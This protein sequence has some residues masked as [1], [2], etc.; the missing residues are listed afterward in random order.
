M[1]YEDALKNIDIN[2]NMIDA[3]LNELNDGSN[4]IENNPKLV[5]KLHNENKGLYHTQK[6]LKKQADNLNSDLLIKNQIIEETKIMH[7]NEL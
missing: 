5:N 7:L 1:L 6:E 2:K 4:S 3:I